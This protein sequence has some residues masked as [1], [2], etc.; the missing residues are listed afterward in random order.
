MRRPVARAWLVALALG[1]ALA[2]GVAASEREDLETLRATTL[3][4]IDALVEQGVLTREQADRLVERA[5]ARAAPP[6]GKDGKPVVRVPY[7]PESVKAEIREQVKQEVIAQARQEGWADVNAL[8][9]WVDRLQWDGDIRLRGQFDLYPPGN[10]PAFFF[11]AQGQNIDNT[12]ENNFRLRLRARLGLQAR[13]SDTV[14]AAFRLTTGNTGDPVST[15]QTLG[16]YNGKYSVSLDRAYLRLTP[17]E[18]FAA[19][20]G[21]VPNPFLST[22]LVWNENLNFEGVSLKFK[23]YTREIFTFRP[24]LTLGAYALETFNVSKDD[25]WLFAAQGGFEWD[26]SS[27]SRLRLGAAYYHYRNIEG[28]P[29]AFGSNVNDFTAPPFRQKGNSLFNIDNDGNPNTVLWAL[30]SQFRLVNLTAVA[31]FEHF[32]PLRVTLT[33]DYVRNVG[34]NTEEILRRTGI[35]TSD[36]KQRTGYYLRAGIGWPALRDRG[37]WQAFVGYKYLEPNAVVDAFNDSDFN[38]GGTNT[39]GYLLGASYAVATNTWLTARWLSA[40]QVVGAPLAIDVFQLDL[41]ARF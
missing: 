38:L 6:A 23:P 36:S 19:D 29:N 7:V 4:L 17:T 33:G 35:A 26:A 37:N 28:V 20:A 11:Q 2:G 39:K 41:N 3:G 8:P 12:T 15:N 25:K 22:D 31:S 13:L 30:L 34:F 1:V 18:W 21:K 24:E 10:A 16:N 9:S 14:A 40:N 5:R 27:N 32:A